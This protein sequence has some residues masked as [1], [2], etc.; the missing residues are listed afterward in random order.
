[1]SEGTKIILLGKSNYAGWTKIIKHKLISEGCLT[2]GKFVEAKEE[3][4]LCIIFCHLSAEIAELTPDDKGAQA[5][6]SFLHRKYGGKNVWDEKS[7]F[8]QIKMISIDIKNLLDI[9]DRGIERVKAAGGKISAEEHFEQ[10]INGCH[11]EFYCSKIR[12]LREAHD[13]EKTDEIVEK[14]RESLL[15]FYDNTP[16]EVRMKYSKKGYQDNSANA[17]S[18]SQ[19]TRHCT[20]CAKASPKF[21]STHDTKFHKDDWV[22]RTKLNSTNTTSSSYSHL[23][24]MGQSQLVRGEQYK[25]APH[26]GTFLASTQSEPP[27]GAIFDTGSSNHF[28]SRKPTQ[29]YIPQVD[30]VQ[31]AAEGKPERIEGH[32]NDTL[33]ALP[34]LNAFYTPTFS[35][36]LVSGPQLMNEGYKIVLEGENMEIS[37]DDKLVETGF[38]CS[39]SGL[40][41]LDSKFDTPPSSNLVEIDRNNAH[42]TMGHLNDQT[43]EKTFAT[44]PNVVLTGKREL[45]CEPCILG[46]GS[47]Q[48]YP[49]I[50]RFEPDILAD[51]HVDIQGPFSIDDREGCR[52]NIKFVDSNSGY[53]VMK[54]ISSKHS[55][56]TAAAADIY[57][58]LMERRTGHSV[59]QFSTDGGTE[60]KGDFNLF[61][62]KNG[63][64]H[65]TGDAYDHHFPSHAERS[66]RTISAMGRTMLLDSKLPRSYYADAMRA[67]V[68]TYNRTVHGKRTLTSYEI[69]YGHPPKLT[70]IHPFGCVGYA[71]VPAEK[72]DKLDPVRREVRLIGYSDDDS[73]QQ[74][75][76]YRLLLSDPEFSSQ[77]ITS[78]DVIFD[79]ACPMTPLKG[80]QSFHNE[81]DLFLVDASSEYAPETDETTSDDLNYTT[82]S[83]YADTDQIPPESPQLHPDDE[84]LSESP[85]ETESLVL[86]I[87]E[88]LSDDQISQIDPI[89]Y[90]DSSEPDQ[91]S[92]S[93]YAG[94]S[95]LNPSSFISSSNSAEEADVHMNC[96]LAQMDDCP[97]SY[98]TAVSCTESKQ[99]K[100]AIEQELNS[101][102]RH[103]V[104]RLHTVTPGSKPDNIVK[105]KWIF[106]KKIASDGSIEKY[107]ARLVACGYSQQHGVDFYEVFAPVAK[108]KS[109]RT[110]LSIAAMQNL[111]V[112]QDDVPNAFLL[113]TLKEKIFME[114]PKG[115]TVPGNVVWDLQKTLYGLKQSPREFYTLVNAYMSKL[116]FK[117]SPADPCIYSKLVNQEPLFV[118][119]YV[120]DILSTGTPASLAS[121]RIP[122]QKEFMMG[123][124]S[125][126][127]W[128]LGMKVDKLNSGHITLDQ[129]LYVSTKVKE[130]DKYIGQ[131]GCST[132]L[133]L[134]YLELVAAGENDPIVI[135]P[136]EFPYRSMAGSAMY[137]MVGTMPGLAFALSVLC[138]HLE[139]PKKVHCEMMRHLYKYLRVNPFILEFKSGGSFT[140]EGYVDASYAN[141]LGSRATSG[142]I[143]TFGNNVISWYSGRQPVV[144]LSTAEAEYIAVTSAAQEAIWLKSLVESLGYVQRTIILHE[145]NQ[146]CIALSKNPQDHKRTKHIQVRFHFVRDLVSDGIIE[147]SFVHT[148]HQLA[149]ICTKALNG[150]AHRTQL[151]KIGHIKTDH[152]SRRQLKYD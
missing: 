24:R 108:L 149:D 46:K 17:A 58:L 7:D 129:T 19:N 104:Y 59:K 143:F 70:H 89:F 113:G 146:A 127:Q 139:K 66:N 75:N 20:I 110:L 84:T 23:S 61:V 94:Y 31:T 10:L 121:F 49:K 43:I 27:N 1:M 95:K 51:V 79:E 152:Q 13:A 45:K 116:G 132:P 21:Q 62:A 147:L 52:N 26:K 119:V 60:F 111:S 131:G 53:I 114:Q 148:K 67:A 81:D 102:K 97:T 112:K 65:K 128:Y 34:L 68:Y 4:S 32:G 50:R 137:A 12:D 8:R 78:S 5:S 136:S 117:Q 2:A 9:L 130:F 87:E 90:S 135:L 122:L 64:I 118:G 35:K 106:K 151:S 22:P 101:I 41:I 74:H 44:L 76:G 99:W 11:Q 105:S 107:K 88:V 80:S 72:R 37:K 82:A 144:A 63:I 83:E 30:Y 98:E 47:R 73:I 91:D 96:F 124:G 69:I 56:R 120:D 77:I 16:V 33:G 109:V 57:T 40:L 138:R 150:S 140:L 6:W 100:H 125:D 54:M 55:S 15:K 142:Y 115:C 103:G 133:P 28:L 123:S 134:N 126:L 42:K 3:K 29:D 92:S 48:N 25:Q 39:K 38:L 18:S 93:D 141:Q 145:D 86:P 36:N 85:S 71:Y 14:A